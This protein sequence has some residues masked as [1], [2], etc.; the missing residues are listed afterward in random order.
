LIAGRRPF[1][2]QAEGDRLRARLAG[3]PVA[4]SRYVPDLP[5]EVEE[6]L[7]HAL[8][9]KPADRYASAMEMKRDLEQPARV[10]VGGRASRLLAPVL[11]KLWWPVAGL[12]GFSLLDPVLLFF[13]IL[14]FLKK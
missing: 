4:P 9:R 8:A 3:D 7:L 5:L 10:V 12:V 14:A 1:D 2:N 11:A 13:V 6:I